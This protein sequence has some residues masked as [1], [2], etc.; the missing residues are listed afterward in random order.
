[1]KAHKGDTWD[2]DLGGVRL[3]S[4]QCSTCIY[5]PGNLMR[6]RPGRLKDITEE[7]RRAQSYLVCHQTLRDGAAP[8]AGEAVCRGFYDRFS[9]TFTQVGDRLRWWREVTPP[10]EDP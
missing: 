7:N 5:R 3:L 9:T 2:R 10:G 6:L 4:R 8:S 1:M